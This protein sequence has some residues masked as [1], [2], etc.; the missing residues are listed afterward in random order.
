MNPYVRAARH[1]VFGKKNKHAGPEISTDLGWANNY[2][3]FRLR[4]CKL[5][6]NFQKKQ[7]RIKPLQVRGYAWEKNAF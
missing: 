3:Y 5:K 2:L 7:F 4:L 6:N 1:Q